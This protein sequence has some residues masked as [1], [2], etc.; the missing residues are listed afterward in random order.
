VRERLVWEDEDGQPED[1]PEP[2]ILNYLWRWFCALTDW[3]EQG[4]GMGPL[5]H[6]EMEAWARLMGISIYPSEAEGMRQIDRLL[7][8]HQYEKDN[9][10]QATFGEQM[11]KIKEARDKLKK[12]G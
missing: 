12:H 7:R 3:R 11:K 1:E 6:T 4:W 9:P 5:R 2:P 8:Q 10:A